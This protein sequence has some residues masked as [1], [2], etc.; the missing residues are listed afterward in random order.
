MLRLLLVLFYLAQFVQG[1]STNTTSP[2]C[3]PPDGTTRSVWGILGSCALTLLICV[4]H[5]IHF[6]IIEGEWT[7]VWLIKG[8]LVLGSF[9]APEVIVAAAAADWK[10]ARERVIEFRDE[11][12]E[13]S[14]KHSFF[15]EMGG[16]VYRDDK[17]LSRTIKSREFLK[18]CKAN[19]IGN[20]IIT[21][22]DIK[23]RS[24]SD[25]LG[26]MILAL[27]LFW[28]MLQVVVRG[29]TGLAVTLIELDTVCMAVLS[30]L[31]ILFWWD[32]PLRPDC[33]YILYYSPPGVELYPRAQSVLSNAWKSDPGCL[34]TLMSYFIRMWKT[35]SATGDEETAALVDKND[36]P[37]DSKSRSL[38]D[39]ID[40]D[41]VTYVSL[42]FT[43]T[44]L[45]GL[46]LIAWNFDFPTETEKILWRVASLALAGS[47]LAVLG[48]VG[49][50]RVV[51]NH[52][53]GWVE[54]WVETVLVA[55]ITSV[56]ILS[57]ASRLLLVALMLASLRALPCSAHQTVSWT[58]YIPHL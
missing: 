41:D 10:R 7:E 45:G 26:K 1:T 28:F 14:M 18:L 8:L 30:L 44:M 3:P 12:Y 33:P 36:K 35:R 56:Y 42:F 40:E 20:P 22:K 34:S 53:N 52:L 27:Q 50:G 11:G 24:K 48:V 17:G 43:W 19:E 13:W 4:W 15:A 25:G 47:P 29:S 21:A 54:K 31:V 23:G 57:A 37:P 9:A 51:E 55:F 46:H 2:S 39:R 58:A 49:L 16:F 6:D 5:S 38:A 32:K